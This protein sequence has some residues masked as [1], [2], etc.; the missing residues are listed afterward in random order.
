MPNPATIPKADRAAGAAMPADVKSL[1]CPEQAG[2]AELLG[3]LLAAKWRREH[4][5]SHTTT[6]RPIDSPPPSP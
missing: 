2:F 3:I 6:A 1:L 4:Q 5:P